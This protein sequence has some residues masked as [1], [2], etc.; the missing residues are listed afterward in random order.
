MPSGV[1]EPAILDGAIV[2]GAGA[3]GLAVLSRCPAARVVLV[4]RSP[5]MAGFAHATLAHPGNAHLGD[6]ASV[7]TA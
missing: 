4:E 7:L 2:I 6:R 1:G 3:A 5:E